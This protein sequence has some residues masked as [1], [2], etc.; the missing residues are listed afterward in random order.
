MFGGAYSFDGVD[1]YIDIG[2]KNFGGSYVKSI[3][4]WA[5]I[6]DCNGI[7]A[8]GE[9]IAVYSDGSNMLGIGL[10]PAGSPGIG[11]YVYDGSLSLRQRYGTSCSEGWHHI[12]AIW[13][14]IDST[15]FVVYVDGVNITGGYWNWDVGW[16]DGIR[17]GRD[18][19]TDPIDAFDGIIDE[20]IYYDKELSQS[21]VLELYNSGSGV[22]V[23]CGTT[24]TYQCSDGIDNDSDGYCDTASGTCADGSTPG[25][26]GCSSAT[27]DD[28]TDP[29]ADNQAPTIPANLAATAISSS[30]IDLNWDASTDDSGMV[31]G[32]SK[33]KNGSPPPSTTKLT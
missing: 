3:S 16:Q 33:N 7:P 5:Y 19:D 13:D 21:E 25:D 24:P 26:P 11:G 28:E 22:S 2:D 15:T 10:Y 14:G 6:N 20:V 23:S 31:S 9:A 12:V 8:D 30:Q 29:I 32:Y 1:D 27:D 4:A 18:I 17:I